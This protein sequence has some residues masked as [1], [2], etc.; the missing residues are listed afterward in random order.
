MKRLLFLSFLLLSAPGY[1]DMVEVKGNIM[2]GEVV[3]DDGKKIQFKDAKGKVHTF[4]KK[5]VTYMQIDKADTG[6]PNATN[7]SKTLQT[8]AAQAFEAAKKAPEALKRVTDGATKN[9]TDTVGKPL[10]RSAANA[11]GAALAR[12]MDDAGKAAAGA[13]KK[14]L[15][16]NEEIASQQKRSEQ[17]EN[18]VISK[19]GYVDNYDAKKGRFGSL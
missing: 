16:A 15:T 14:V 13:N 18:R 3:S 8:K 2:N 11:S 9:F 1:A 10:D 4:D 6:K 17:G 5:S 12:S 19:A 7:I